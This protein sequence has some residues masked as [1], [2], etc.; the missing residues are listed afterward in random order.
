MGFS[1]RFLAQDGMYGT[2]GIR[3]LDPRL[4]ID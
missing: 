2:A 1:G 3:T 4:H